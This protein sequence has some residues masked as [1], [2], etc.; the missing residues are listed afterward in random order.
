MGRCL[1]F[2]WDTEFGK[3]GD[4]VEKIHSV[5]FQF[6]KWLPVFQWSLQLPGSG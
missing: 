6:Y 4:E 3:L 2:S 1:E 5:V